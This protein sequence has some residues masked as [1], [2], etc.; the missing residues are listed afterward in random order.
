MIAGAPVTQVTGGRGDISWSLPQWEGVKHPNDKATAT[1]AVYQEAW[2]GRASPEPRSPRRP[3]PGS[4]FAGNT[5]ARRSGISMSSRRATRMRSAAN[6]SSIRAV[7][8]PRCPGPDQVPGLHV[9]MKYVFDTGSG[10]QVAT[11]RVTLFAVHGLSQVRPRPPQ[12]ESPFQR[13]GWD[14]MAHP[15]Q[16]PPPPPPRGGEAHPPARRNG[17]PISEAMAG[18]FW[19]TARAFRRPLR[20]QSPAAAMSPGLRHRAARPALQPK[21]SDAAPARCRM[22]WIFPN[23]SRPSS[24]AHGMPWSPAPS[25]RWRVTATLLPQSRSRWPTFGKRTSRPTR[26]VT[27]WSRTIPPTLHWQGGDGGSTLIPRGSTDESGSDRRTGFAITDS[28]DRR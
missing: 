2:N 27:G 24:Q 12:R 6:R 15:D 18:S 20:L 25:A 13:D 1:E 26:R 11:R 10:S 8:P 21:P 5:T 14:S 17:A 3:S 22:S 23:S 28:R 9:T 19:A 16:L 7:R 4:R